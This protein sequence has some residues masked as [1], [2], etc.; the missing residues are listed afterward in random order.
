MAPKT[1]K[2]ESVFLPYPVAKR[3]DKEGLEPHSF[4]STFDLT[5]LANVVCWDRN[6]AKMSH[7]PGH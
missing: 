1:S 6:L 3:Q 7:S 5:A 2:T 4:N